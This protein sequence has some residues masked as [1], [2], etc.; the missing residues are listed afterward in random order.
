MYRSLALILVAV[1]VGCSG[2]RTVGTQPPRS[3]VEVNEVL[4][5]R[6][7]TAQ[8]DDG[9]TVKGEGLAVFPDS[10]RFAAGSAVLPTARVL[11]ITYERDRFSPGQGAAGGALVGGA[12]AGL[13][14]ASPGDLSSS[15]CLAYAGIAVMSGA[16]IG[17]LL[18]E[19]EGVGPR[20]RVAYEGP[21]SRYTSAG[22]GERKDVAED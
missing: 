15:W 17:A 21:V 19:A 5:G 9:T 12:V 14:A 10:V 18:G 1:F 16:I 13:C 2:S 22:V 3:L 6:E 11:R 7:A 20:E 8:L 4:A